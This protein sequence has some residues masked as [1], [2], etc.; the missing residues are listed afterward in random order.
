MNEMMTFECKGSLIFTVLSTTKGSKPK[1]LAKSGRILIK[2]NN[3]SALTLL[4]WTRKR[5]KLELGN[6]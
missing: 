3:F 2:T 4:Q 6:G 5:L 1:I